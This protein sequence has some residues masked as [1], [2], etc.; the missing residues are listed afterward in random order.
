VH[1]DTK[2]P[3][4][5]QAFIDGISTYIGNFISDTGDGDTV[6]RVMSISMA[7]VF[8]RAI[9]ETPIPPHEVEAMLDEY[10]QQLRTLTKTIKQELATY[11]A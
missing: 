7:H 8:A 1:D 10:C 11:G 6:L 3:L 2:R 9:V 4:T 5:E